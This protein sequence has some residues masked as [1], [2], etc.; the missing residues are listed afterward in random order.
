MKNYLNY[1]SSEYD[2]GP[3]SL[4]NGIRYLFEREE[5]SPDI[6]KFIMLYCMDTYNESG[7]PC[8]HGTSAAAMK[9]IGSWLNQTSQVRRLP[10]SCEFLSKEAVTV[11][12]GSRI[13]Q[14]LEEG[15]VTV[16]HVF[17]EVPHYVLLTGLSDNGEAL[18]FDPYYE[19]EGTPEFD[20]E[21]YSKGIRFINGQPK[22]A[23]RAVSLERLN[24]LTK[25]YYEMG[26]FP[27]REA[28]IMKRTDG[29]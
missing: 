16:L 21:Y 29:K 20:A 24:R 13:H 26:D 25:G 7:E 22:R 12:P 6:I 15:A 28:L 2:C 17:L 9:F 5:I 14:A 4:I 27:C 18:L 8:K 10:F 19:E 23:N 3:V 11:L 1:Q